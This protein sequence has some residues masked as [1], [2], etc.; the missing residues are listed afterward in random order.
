MGFFLGFLGSLVSF[1]WV[2]SSSSFI[3]GGGGG[4]PGERSSS[5]DIPTSQALMASL[6][7]QSGQHLIYTYLFVLLLNKNC[8]VKQ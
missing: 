8:T 5:D 4:E 2:C 1:E 6:G 7:D 3:S